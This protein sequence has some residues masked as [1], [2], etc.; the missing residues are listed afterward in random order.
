MVKKSFATSRIALALHPTLL[1][2]PNPLDGFGVA[3]DV[4]GHQILRNACVNPV[5]PMVNVCI[6]ACR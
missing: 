1:F 5:N 6:Q 3:G 4:N 2:N